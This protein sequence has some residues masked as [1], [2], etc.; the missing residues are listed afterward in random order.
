[1]D[2]LSAYLLLDMGPY[3]QDGRYPPIL[4]IFLTKIHP[5]THLGSNLDDD[6]IEHMDR[7]KT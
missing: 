1:L 4:G 2:K 7:T 5:N 3:T 6:L